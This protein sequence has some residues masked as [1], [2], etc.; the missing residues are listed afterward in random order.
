M[1]TYLPPQDG[2][3]AEFGRCAHRF[4]RSMREAFG[5]Y[6][7]LDLSE[8]AFLQQ[9]DEQERQLKPVFI[10]VLILA[11]AVVVSQIGGVQ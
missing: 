9:L 11:V 4:P 8:E 7:R 10:A 1:S 5:S 3:F 6:A 2:L